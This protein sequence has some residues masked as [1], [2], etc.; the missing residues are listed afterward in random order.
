MKY[1]PYP[2]AAAIRS[3][4]KVGWRYYATEAEA[5]ACAQIAEHNGEVDRANGY[6][7]GYCSPGSITGPDR[8]NWH[9]GLWEVCT[10]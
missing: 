2:E 5:K 8:Q 6:D 1:K 7:H 9:S 3:G 10:C 4:C